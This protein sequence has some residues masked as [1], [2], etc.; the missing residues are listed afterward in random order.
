MFLI[1]RNTSSVTSLIVG[2]GPARHIFSEPPI[3]RIDVDATIKRKIVQSGT[4][5]GRPLAHT[6][7]A[8]LKN[9]KSP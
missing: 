2:L 5:P 9:E 3:P 4:R 6:T 8:K 7:I 1:G